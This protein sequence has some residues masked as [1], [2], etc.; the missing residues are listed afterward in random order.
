M[1]YYRVKLRKDSE[2]ITIDVSA[3]SKLEAMT[4]VMHKNIGL[5]ISAKPIIYKQSKFKWFNNTI[6][7]EELFTILS[8]I[9]N[10][11]STG[12]SLDK[13]LSLIIEQTTN[14]K[15]KDMFLNTL[16]SV[17]SGKSLYQ[18]LLP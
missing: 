17:E 14:K 18:S 6:K 11:H 10:L 9:S 4:I 12:M 1:T 16:R 2:I 5:V 15:T 13:T 7:S 3:S 8:T